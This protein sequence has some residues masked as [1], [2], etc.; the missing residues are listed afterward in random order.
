MNDQTNKLHERWEKN[1]GSHKHNLTPIGKL[2]LRAKQKALAQTLGSLKISNAIDV[3]C[4]LGYTLSVFKNLGI[5]ALG[6]DAS[7]TAAEICKSKGLKAEQKKLEE[8]D[9]KYDLV[10]SDGMLEHFLNFEPYAEQMAQIS[11]GYVIIIQTDHSSFLGKT[12]I[13]LAE[14]L[15]GSK[16]VFEYNYR[17]QDFIDVFGKYGFKLI[18]EKRIFI[19]IFRLLLF[20]KI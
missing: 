19:G 9:E 12:S 5:N 16:N 15:R 20:E 6:I 11:N 4:G 14:L 17:I 7:P 8:V 10:F 1:W 18:L 2:M 3:G 13:Y